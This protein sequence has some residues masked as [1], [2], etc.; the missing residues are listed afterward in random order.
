M[1]MGHVYPEKPSECWSLK[2]HSS[3][4]GVPVSCRLAAITIT[5]FS[6]VTQRCGV[7]IVLQISTRIRHSGLCG[8]NR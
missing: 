8:G 1:R 5:L 4:L 6:T 3:V 7:N 2:L